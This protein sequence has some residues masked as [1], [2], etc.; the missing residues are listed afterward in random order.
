MQVNRIQL[1][2]ASIQ[3]TLKSTVRRAIGGPHSHPW[4]PHEKPDHEQ[5]LK[6]ENGQSGDKGYWEDKEG[7]EQHQPEK[8][9]EEGHKVEGLQPPLRIPARRGHRHSHAASYQVRGNNGQYAHQ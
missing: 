6:G 5:H 3:G 4:S 7:N 1:Q 9:N 8:P 2:T